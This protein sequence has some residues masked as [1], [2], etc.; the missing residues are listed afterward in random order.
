VFFFVNFCMTGCTVTDECHI[1][2]VDYPVDGDPNCTLMQYWAFI[3]VI[4][5]TLSALGH[6]A[7]KKLLTEIRYSVLYWCMK[8]IYERLS[9]ESYI[10]ISFSCKLG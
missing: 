9:A 8:L 3:E 10:Y 5:S 7:L 4:M 1:L 2:N 6:V